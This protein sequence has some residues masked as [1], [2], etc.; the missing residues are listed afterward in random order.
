MKITRE[1]LTENS[2]LDSFYLPDQLKSNEKFQE[3][4]KLQ[5][6][7]RS[8]IMIYGKLIEIPRFQKSYLK[9]SNTIIK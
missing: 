4:W 9:Q 8:E 2:W 1:Y 6:K 7:K 3:L 5:P